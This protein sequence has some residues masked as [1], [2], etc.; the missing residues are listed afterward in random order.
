MH[1]TPLN[2]NSHLL[3][4]WGSILPKLTSIFKFNESSSLPSR[5]ARTTTPDFIVVFHIFRVRKHSISDQSLTFLKVIYLFFCALG[6]LFVCLFFACICVCVRVSDL[7]VRDSCEL[8][9]G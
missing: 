7:V 8:P 3:L 6:F 1:S 9:C 4:R 2:C 5:V